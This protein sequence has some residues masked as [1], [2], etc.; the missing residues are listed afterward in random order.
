MHEHCIL[1]PLWKKMEAKREA[2][3][4]G[5]KQTTL[6]GVFEKFQGPKEFMKEAITHA[7][8]QLVVCNDQ[9]SCPCLLHKL[10]IC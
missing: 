5:E 8:A 7:V 10:M 1:R 3:Q 9:V 4:T 6:D 2:V